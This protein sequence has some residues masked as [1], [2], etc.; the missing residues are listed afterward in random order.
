MQRDVSSNI[1]AISSVSWFGI[2]DKSIVSAN[3]FVNSSWDSSSTAT[4]AS[5]NL[6]GNNPMKGVLAGN[7]TNAD[8]K[9]TSSFANWSTGNPFTGGNGV[10]A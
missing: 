4:S 7:T 1:D 3:P 2:T 6:F 8:S 10:N 5:K 9:S